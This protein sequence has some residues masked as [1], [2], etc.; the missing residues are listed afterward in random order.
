MKQY[1]Q[2]NRSSLEKLIEYSNKM[3][4]KQL[5]FYG[6]IRGFRKPYY[7][8]RQNSIDGGDLRELNLKELNQDNFMG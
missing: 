7:T 6:K 8:L 4:K 1:A 2:D 5:K 3:V